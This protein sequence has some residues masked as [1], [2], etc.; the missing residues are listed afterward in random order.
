[1][2]NPSTIR[3]LLR[4]GNQTIGAW[5]QIPSPEIAEIFA[6]SNHFDW[7]VVDDEHGAFSTS[8]FPSI[9]RS[10]ELYG[11]LPLI[12]LKDNTYRSARDVAEFG[13]SG[14][15]VPKVNSIETLTVIFN[16]I[17][18]PPLGTRGVGFCRGNQYGL[19]FTDS[20]DTPS[21]LLIGMI[22][23]IEALDNL[24]SILSFPQLDAILVGPYDL[25]T[26]LSVPGQFDHPNFVS[27]ISDIKDTARK[28]SVPYG[29]HIVKNDP[30]EFL[31][32]KNSGA[33]FIVYS[34]DSVILSNP[35]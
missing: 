2:T 25:S 23:S 24:D 14:Y 18:Y 15:I 26:S 10:I 1:M 8:I 12:R 9:C 6:A 11:K 3:S 22:E 29:I 16:A 13:F 32:V 17:N 35:F 34:L 7:V 30:S 27:A 4:S 5:M 21:P 19:N 33:Q 20:L 28:Y 31:N